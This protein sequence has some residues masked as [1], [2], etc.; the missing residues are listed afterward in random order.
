MTLGKNICFKETNLVFFPFFHLKNLLIPALLQ[1]RMVAPASGI[2]VL[3]PFLLH[4][5]K[6]QVFSSFFTQILESSGALGHL[7]W[8]AGKCGCKHTPDVLHCCEVGRA[9]LECHNPAPAGE[10]LNGM[11]MGGVNSTSFLSPLCM[12][13]KEGSKG[14]GWI[15]PKA[16]VLFSVRERQNFLLSSTSKASAEPGD[17]HF[18]N[19]CTAALVQG[20]T[21]FIHLSRLD[22]IIIAA[23]RDG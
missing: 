1:R 20:F 5:G 16:V 23:N 8:G 18:R 21:C 9:C 2:V 7:L 15:H 10:Q 19:S 22:I 14:K 6:M 17:I 12:L 4:T 3:S 11:G 13:G